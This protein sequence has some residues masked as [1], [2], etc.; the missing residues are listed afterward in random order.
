MAFIDVERTMVEASTSLQIPWLTS[1]LVDLSRALHALKK[2]DILSS[3]HQ[4]P[5]SVRALIQ[6]QTLHKACNGLAHAIRNRALQLF[7]ASAITMGNTITALLPFLDV[8]LF[9]DGDIVVRILSA[10][11][12]AAVMDC[13]PAPYCPRKK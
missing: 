6:T 8:S 5:E 10:E 3:I 13:L 7:M 1:S 4:Q 12:G 9:T 2:P 11:F